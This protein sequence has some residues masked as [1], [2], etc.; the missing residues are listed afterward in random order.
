MHRQRA[1][2]KQH[3]SYVASTLSRSFFSL[4]SPAHGYFI[5]RS[6]PDSAPS[7]STH[8]IARDFLTVR[9]ALTVTAN[10]DHRPSFE[11]RSSRLLSCERVPTHPIFFIP[12]TH[13]LGGI[14]FSP[15]LAGPK[16]KF[17]C[18]RE[19]AQPCELH[20][21]VILRAFVLTHI[22]SHGCSL[23]N[24]HHLNPLTDSDALCPHLNFE[25]KTT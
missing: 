25:D 16:R 13:R 22:F 19:L 7:R 10:E 8:H 1:C 11:A 3:I 2:K 18:S 15:T 4:F 5:H 6:D 17:L 9:A 21:S 24:Y 14:S 20:T 23:Q 12:Q